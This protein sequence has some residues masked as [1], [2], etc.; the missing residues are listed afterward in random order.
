MGSLR[1]FSSLIVL[2]FTIS[3]SSSQNKPVSC[4]IPEPV[5][6]KFLDGSYTITDKIKFCLPENNV[7]ILA[8]SDILSELFYNNTGIR[9]G[10]VLNNKEV[11]SGVYLRLNLNWDSTIGNEGYNL[12]IDKRSIRIAANKTAGLFYGFQSLLQLLPFKTQ[13]NITGTQKK[14]EV[15]CLE[16]TDYPRFQWRGLMLDVCRHFFTIEEVKRMINEMVQYKF[17]IL[18]LHLSDDQ[19]WR[20]EIKELPELTKTGAWRVP[21]TGLWW[22]REPPQDGE[23]AIYGGFYSQDQIIDLVRYAS[24]RHVQILP[25]IDVPGHSRAAIAS[26]NYLSCTKLPYKVN[27]GSFFQDVAGHPYNSVV[28]CPGQE[29]TYEFLEKVFNEVAELFPFE[30]IHVG[31]DETFKGFWSECDSCKKCMAYN[32]LKNTDELQSY[33]IKRVEKI[34]NAKGKNLIG[35]D[36]ILEGGLAPDATVMS[37]RGQKGG[38]EAAKQ[39][40][41]VIMTPNSYAYL[42]LYQGDPVIEPPTYGMLRLKTCY[43]FEPIPDGIDQSFV[44]GGQGNLWT[45]SVPNFRQV[46]YMLWPRSFALA[47]VLWSPKEKRDWNDF[48]QRTNIHLSRLDHADINFSRSFLDVIIH[49]LKDDNGNLIIQLETE[50]DNLEIFYTFDNT[51]PDF[52]SLKYKSGEKLTIPKDADKFSAV[53]Y[54]NNKQA[55]RTISIPIKDMERRVSRKSR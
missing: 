38:I 23:V 42:D 3:N 21:R 35:W 47:E 25:E 36:E 37:W 49:P 52:Y 51:F 11:K 18:H 9:P 54:K 14:L 28:L 22:D 44:L 46:E 1:F 2:V 41:K 7:E 31:G 29:A 39:N 40:H 8:L 45:E 53:T 19:G 43:R 20:I 34:L 33:F 17:N 6:A 32:N 16:I 55:G 5:L 12:T 50:V 15:P 10:I 24:E 13:E 4:I 27:P 26:Y 30:Y 48:I